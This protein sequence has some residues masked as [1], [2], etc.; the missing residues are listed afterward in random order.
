MNNIELSETV[1]N[2]FP[3]VKTAR[4]LHD[5]EGTLWTDLD[6]DI[7]MFA[8]VNNAKFAMINL[9]AGNRN[10]DSFGIE[11]IQLHYHELE[12]YTRYFGSV[13]ITP[14]N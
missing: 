11:S 6:G 5:L 1:S 7:H 2:K 3:T 9:K 13:T 8:Q 4:D 12:T 10:V 14:Q